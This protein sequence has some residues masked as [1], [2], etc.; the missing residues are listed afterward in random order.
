MVLRWH[1][2]DG[3]PLHAYGRQMQD[4]AIANV[5]PEAK[6]V[7]RWEPVEVRMGDGSTVV[8]KR[9]VF[10][11]DRL[12]YGELP[13]DVRLAPRV[14]PAVFGLGLIENV[15]AAMVV[16]WADPS[17]RNSDGISGRAIWTNGNLGKFGWKSQVAALRGQVVA[18]AIEDIGISTDEFPRQNCTSAQAGCAA[19]T[20]GGEPEMGPR[21]VDRL[22]RYLA[23]LGVPPRRSPTSAAVAR[24]SALFG[25]F[26]CAACHRPMLRTVA[27]A[28]PDWL[29]NQT[30]FAYTD[31]LVHDLGA[32]LSDPQMSHIEYAREWRTAPLWGLGLIRAVNGHQQLLHDGR[33]D[34]VAEAIL[35]HG[36]EGLPAREKFRWANQS[37][38]DDL[39]AF[40]NDL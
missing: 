38:R 31:L 35:W 37:E 5:T 16:A 2:A 26:G 30:F 23:F 13:S 33:A 27:D 40:V 1:H 39:V 11:V 17:D 10:G 19:A 3:T 20:H 32:A 22:T 24:G 36:G 21:D 34:G 4:Q 9:P 12:A 7:V 15:D 6:L 8:L 25:D 29:A 28:Q 14:A 18:A